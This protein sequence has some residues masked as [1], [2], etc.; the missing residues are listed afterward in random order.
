MGTG[1]HGTFVAEALRE[2]AGDLEMDVHNAL[3]LA[4]IGA[5]LPHILHGSGLAL[6]VLAAGL[7]VGV[8]IHHAAEERRH[9]FIEAVH[10][11]GVR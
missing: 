4:E 3:S 8:E 6:G 1:P 7:Y 5:E 2:R 9:E 11:L 10:T